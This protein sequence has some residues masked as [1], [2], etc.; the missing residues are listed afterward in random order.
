MHYKYHLITTLRD[1]TFNDALSEKVRRSDSRCQWHVTRFRPT[2]ANAT[3]CPVVQGPAC[4]L[5]RSV[6]RR[7]TCQRP[8]ALGGSADKGSGLRKAVK[9]VTFVFGIARDVGH[10]GFEM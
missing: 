6:I 2:K 9:T 7:V 10:H 8:G 5:K 1:E 4:M 3:N